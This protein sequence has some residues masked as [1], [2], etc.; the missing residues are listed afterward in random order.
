MKRFLRRGF[1]MRHQLLSCTIFLATIFTCV[2]AQATGF[3]LSTG[4]GGET[5]KYDTKYEE[6]RSNSHVSVIFDT[7][8]SDNHLFNY[9]L[10]LGTGSSE[11]DTYGITM[12][13]FVVTHDFGFQL[14]HARMVKVWLGPQINIANYDSHESNNGL[15]Y[16]GTVTGFG[17]GPV[18]GLNL[19]VG[20]LVSLSLDAGIRRMGYVGFLNTRNSAG[21]RL[22]RTEIDAVGSGNFMDFSI[23]FRFNE[24]AR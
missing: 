19:N 12:S 7:N 5:W 1:I 21:A 3:G 20:S 9:R 6:D 15:S 10:S 22:D 2:N 23:I 8:L 18:L 11:P 4:G 17:V 16:K 14:V 24:M 13:G